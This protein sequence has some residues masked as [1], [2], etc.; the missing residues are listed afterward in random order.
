VLSLLALKLTSTRRVSHVYEL[1]ADPA[2]A[3]PYPQA[4]H[5]EFGGEG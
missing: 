1:A 4:A 3:P 2:A 5:E